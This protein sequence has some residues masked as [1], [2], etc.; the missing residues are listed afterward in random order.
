MPPE[1]KL[2]KIGSDRYGLLFQWW[3]NVQGGGGYVHYVALID[4]REKRYKLILGEELYQTE[5]YPE[6][7]IPHLEVILTFK[8]DFYNI[9]I[10]SKIYKFREGKYKMI[11]K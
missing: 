4:L 7:V 1:A 11:S 2:I 9:R 8:G 5:D 3:R 6:L 10:N